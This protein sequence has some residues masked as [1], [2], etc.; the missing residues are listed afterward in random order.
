MSLPLNGL[1]DLLAFLAC[2]EER[3][4]AFRIEQDRPDSVMVVFAVLHFY[5]EVD[6]FEDHCEFSYY[7]GTEDVEDDSRKLLAIMDGD[8]PALARLGLPGGVTPD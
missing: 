5:G 7:Y 6:F 4:I 2:L 8:K 3:K 1:P